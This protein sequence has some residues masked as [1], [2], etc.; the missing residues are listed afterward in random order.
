NHERVPIG[1]VQRRAVVELDKAVLRIKVSF[2][3]APLTPGY[4]AFGRMPGDLCCIMRPSTHLE[5]E[6]GRNTQASL[7]RRTPGPP[8]R[9]DYSR[10]MHD[11]CERAV[12]AN[13]AF[14]VVVTAAKV[15]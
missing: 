13:D 1:A 7:D 2:T 5:V 4:V 14:P 3:A 9:D 6:T 10:L 11:S 8:H 15:E 12:I